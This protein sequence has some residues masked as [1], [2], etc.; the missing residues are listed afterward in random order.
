VSGV[1]IRLHDDLA[2]FAELVRPLLHEDPVRHTIGVSLLANRS[3]PGAPRDVVTMLTAH[4][5]GGVCGAT[6]GV[7]GLALIASA[8]PPVAAPAAADFLAERS[9]GPPP[10]VTGPRENAEAFAAAWCRRTGDTV[11]VEMALRLYALAQLRPPI[12]VP[13][14]ARLA[15]EVDLPLVARWNL[16]F[17]LAAL[18]SGWAHEETPEEVARR[19]LAAGLGNL[20]WEV[21]GEPVALAA[22]SVPAA[23]MSR[24]ASVW[25]PP[26]HRGRGFGSAATAAASRWALD[27]GAEH[28]VLFTDLANPVSN[29]IYQRIGYRP[30]HDAVDLAFARR[31]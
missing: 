17:A 5:G 12:G 21:G 2:T 1:D 16:D 31:T 15:T 4:E 19:Q 18:P 8:L 27:A 20:I 6:M 14:A 7:R 10:G 25:T 29:S 28:V 9:A 11:R 22:A 3:R 24:I 30:V 23:G 26:E 13:G